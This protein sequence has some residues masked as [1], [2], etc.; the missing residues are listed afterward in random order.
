MAS[1][2]GARAAGTDGS[3]FAFRQTVDSK[4]QRAA[5]ARAGCK[6][7]LS[8]LLVY[9]PAQLM[10]YVG[11]IVMNK[12]DVANGRGTPFAA[13]AFVGF[14]LTF[15]A[16][17]HVRGNKLNARWLGGITKAS[18][19]WIIFDAMRFFFP[20]DRSDPRSPPAL[21]AAGASLA[22]TL[23]PPLPLTLNNAAR[24]GDHVPRDLEP[25]RRRRRARVLAAGRIHGVDRGERGGKGDS[26]PT[27]EGVPRGGRDGADARDRRRVRADGDRDRRAEAR[28][29]QLPERE[30]A[31]RVARA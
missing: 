5:D 15:A 3:D 10:F 14:A 12:A 31:L 8:L 20:S 1:K 7:L 23:T 9:F 17:A 24:A 6:R 28:R 4:Y 19:R 29:V 22:R 21:L 16:H 2:A 11:P 18:E 27:G 13:C 30:D 25:R 26:S